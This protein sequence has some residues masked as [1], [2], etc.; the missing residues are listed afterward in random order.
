AALYYLPLLVGMTIGGFPYGRPK[1]TLA[2]ITVY[3]VQAAFPWLVLWRAYVANGASVGIDFL[4]RFFSLSW[5]RGVRLVVKVL[6]PFLALAIFVLKPLAIAWA[7]DHAA[8]I[9]ANQAALPI[10]GKCIGA[11][12]GLTL[13]LIFFAL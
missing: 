7:G 10:L 9:L 8:F 12:I 1:A 5:V 11:V 3:S 6:L 2:D 13:G 4:P